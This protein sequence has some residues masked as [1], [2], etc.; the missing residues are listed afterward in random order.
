MYQEVE[1][2]ESYY[3]GSVKDLDHEPCESGQ[4]V[5]DSQGALLS[6]LS[7]VSGPDHRAFNSHFARI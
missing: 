7:K 6:Q 3:T 5:S 1:H 4:E 2:Y